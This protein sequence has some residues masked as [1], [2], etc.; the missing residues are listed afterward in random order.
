[1]EKAEEPDE[2][3]EA[4]LAQIAAESLDAPTEEDERPLDAEDEA[5]LARVANEDLEEPR[6]TESEPEHAPAPAPDTAVPRRRAADADG[7]SLAVLD[8]SGEMVFAPMLPSISRSLRTMD[9]PSDG[10]SEPITSIL[11]RIE[12][13]RLQQALSQSQQPA[14]PQQ[15]QREEAPRPHSPERSQLWV[16][17]YAPRTFADLLSDGQANRDVVSWLKRWDNLVFGRS[18]KRPNNNAADCSSTNTLPD[19]PILLMSG[20]PGFGKTTLAHIAANHCGY[21]S[22]EVNASDERTESALDSRIEAALETQSVTGDRRPACLVLDEIDGLASSTDGK[23]AVDHI[24]KLADASNKAATPAQPKHAQKGKDRSS[25]DADNHDDDGTHG[26]SHAQSGVENYGDEGG[27]KEQPPAKKAK[28][29]SKSKKSKG[30]KRLTRPIVCI[31]NDL[32]A[33]AL[34]TLRQRAEVV[35]MGEPSRDALVRRLKHVS[36]LEGVQTDGTALQTIVDQSD[37][38]ARASLHALQY[39]SRKNSRV[40]RACAC[41]AAIG[42]KDTRAQA[43]DAVRAVLGRSSSRLSQGSNWDSAIRTFQCAGDS[44]VVHEG[45][46]ENLP[47][48]KYG[49]VSVKKTASA[50]MWLAVG[51]VYASCARRNQQWALEQYR[52]VASLGVRRNAQNTM[53]EPKLQFPKKCI[54]SRRMLQTHENAVS[55][56]VHSCK[57]RSQRGLWSL[58]RAAIETLPLMLDTLNPTLRGTATHL[59]SD[60]DKAKLAK[61][62]QVLKEHGLSFSGQEA[63]LDPPLEQIAALSEHMLPRERYAMPRALRHA[64]SHEAT[65]VA[66]GAGKTGRESAEEEGNTLGKRR[67]SCGARAQEVRFKHNEGVTNSVRRPVHISDLV[68]S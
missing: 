6:T 31:C 11:S 52:N 47:N 7:S 58:S 33:P 51:D 61:V 22:V 27:N 60:G 32:Y 38:D 45:L 20:P 8:S 40:T 2:T 62:A 54:E 13:R 28:L 36:N 39:L 9:G 42:Q 66:I 14:H 16:H 29:S 34:R 23:S 15:P 59:L 5:F 35:R 65:M 50:T 57:A 3:E 44:D 49:D 46:H 63:A 67:R 48:A 26:E 43:L 25:D 21:R 64:A 19:P 12:D 24:V 30:A 56:W 1:M 17:K 37:C 68:P 4:W 55:T 53:Y 10:L 18:N 41:S